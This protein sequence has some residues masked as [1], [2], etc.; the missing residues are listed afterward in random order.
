VSLVVTYW[1]TDHKELEFTHCIGLNEP[2]PLPEQ[3]QCKRSNVSGSQT[4]E[5]IGLVV[6]LQFFCRHHLMD[7]ENIRDIFSDAHKSVQIGN[8][9]DQPRI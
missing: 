8:Q 2:F 3:R 1:F 4:G 9:N 7:V 5:L 6:L